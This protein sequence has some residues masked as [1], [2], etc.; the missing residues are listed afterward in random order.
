M[1]R[2]HEDNPDYREERVLELIRKFEHQ[3]EEMYGII[4]SI[5]RHTHHHRDSTPVK[6]VLTPQPPVP[7]R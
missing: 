5:F 6:I 3:L 1:S 2:R 7:K 4:K